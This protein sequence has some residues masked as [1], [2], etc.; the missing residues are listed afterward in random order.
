[1]VVEELGDIVNISVNNYPTA[2]SVTM[3]LNFFNRDVAFSHTRY[4]DVSRWPMEV[5]VG[6]RLKRTGNRR[7]CSSHD[8]VSTTIPSTC[9]A[10]KPA[11]NMVLRMKHQHLQGR[12]HIR[13]GLSI[14]QFK[15]DPKQHPGS[16]RSRGLSRSSSS[17]KAV[18]CLDFDAQIFHGT[19]FG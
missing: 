19:A 17:F 7:T 4:R 11:Q 8:Q 10:Q 2:F 18:P 5:G 16:Q 6:S 3:F 1:M 14:L 15:G 9:V 12:L 13:M